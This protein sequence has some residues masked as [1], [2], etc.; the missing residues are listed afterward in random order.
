MS[1]WHDGFDQACVYMKD[2]LSAFTFLADL[3]ERTLRSFST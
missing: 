1:N 2:E 3:S